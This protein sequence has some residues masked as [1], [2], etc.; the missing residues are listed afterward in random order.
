MRGTP[1]VFCLLIACSRF[2]PAHAG[3]TSL[4]G[5][6]VTGT[7]VHP[8]ACGEHR[9]VQH[10]AGLPVGS[11]PRMRGTLNR[12][13]RVGVRIR[14]I[15]AH[16][17]NT[18]PGTL[19]SSEHT[20]HP[21]ACGEHVALQ[22]HPGEKAGSSPRM[23]GTRRFAEPIAFVSRF[24]PAHAGNTWMPWQKRFWSSVHPRACGEHPHYH[25]LIFN[26]NGSSPR[27]RGTP[28][29]PPA[30]L[31]QNRFIPAH[32]GNTSARR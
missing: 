8:R 11:S 28:L 7:S 24:I 4:V 5:M 9:P 32:A 22:G 14:F 18:G 3:N 12:P 29:Q 6:V 15:P 20:V 2:I 23:R 17:G 25:L 27:M 10:D 16:A 13:D 21:R 1:S 31:V 30:R 26:Y 19:K